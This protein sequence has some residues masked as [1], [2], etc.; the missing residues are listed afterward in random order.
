[1]TQTFFEKKIKPILMY[2]GTIGAAFMS[3][4]YIILMFV[5]VFGFNVQKDL[6][7]SIIFAVINAV[8]GFL[9][10]QMLKVQGIDFAKQLPENKKVLDEWN[11]NRV[12]TRRT[13]SLTFYW[14]KSTIGDAISKV[15]SIAVTTAGIIYIVVEGSNDYNMLLLSAV[16]L[17]MFL[18][19]G[20]I[21]LVNA[22]DFFNT[23]HIP[24]IKEKLTELAENQQ[25]SNKTQHIQPIDEQI[26]TQEQIVEESQESV[27][28]NVHDRQ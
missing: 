23:M 18:C 9:I 4:A 20:F 27:T 12:K 22:Y 7:N 6:S 25:R 24:F 15:I 16:N 17:I 19:F 10:M 13:H 14:I 21:S 28:D 5:L 2:V 11:K 3:I 1:M 26:V 8:V